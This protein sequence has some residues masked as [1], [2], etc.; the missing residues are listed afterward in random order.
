ML[1]RIP[2]DQLETMGSIMNELSNTRVLLQRLIY[3]TLP[4]VW[5]VLRRNIGLTSAETMALGCVTLRDMGVD[6]QVGG[7]A[8]SQVCT[9]DAD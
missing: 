4:C 3:P 1:C 2:I 7:T 5:V 8:V 9:E 6:L